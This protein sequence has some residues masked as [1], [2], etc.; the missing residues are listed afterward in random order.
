MVFSKDKNTWFFNSRPVVGI[1]PY[2]NERYTIRNL[3]AGNHF[4]VAADDIEAGEW[5]DPVM[6]QQLSATATRITIGEHRPL[7]PTIQ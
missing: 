1:R 3:P 2:G 4:V 6:L 5:Y 7:P